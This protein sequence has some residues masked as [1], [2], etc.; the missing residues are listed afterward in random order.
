MQSHCNTCGGDR[1]HVVIHEESET[2]S[3]DRYD[4]D[5]GTTYQMVKCGGCGT[6]SMRRETWCSEWT[7]D[8][9]RPEGKVDYFPPRLFRKI[10]AWHAD[11]QTY[12]PAEKTIS[13]LL[14][15]IYVALQNDLRRLAA[16]GIRS[17]LEHMMIDKVSDQGSFKKNITK[18]KDSGFISSVQM[19]FIETALEA[20]HASIH[21]DFKPTVA[22]LI[23]LIDIS[24]SLVQVLYIQ[25][26]QAAAIKATVPQRK[27]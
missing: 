9:G 27:K 7:D 13:D 24:E 25:E 15:E 19:N 26:H 16:M 14:Q 10:P 18:F 4:V 12:L 6:F 21:R 1:E 2:W 22:V 3:D 11:L 17:L 5:G 23:S 8:H 20:G